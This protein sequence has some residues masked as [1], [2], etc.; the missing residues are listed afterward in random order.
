MLN[1]IG[2]KNILC[3]DFEASH[4]KKFEKQNEKAIR[5]FR[6]IR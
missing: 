2:A 4:L 3:N 6:I 1:P 5:K